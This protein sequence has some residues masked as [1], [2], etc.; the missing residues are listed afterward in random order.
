DGSLITIYGYNPNEDPYL[1]LRGAEP[2]T[3]SPEHMPEVDEEQVLELLAFVH[4]LSP[5]AGFEKMQREARS[6][7]VQYADVDVSDLR[8]PHMYDD[9]AQTGQTDG[10][11]GWL[12]RRSKPW[13]RLNAGIVAPFVGGERQISADGVAKITSVIIAESEQY[14]DWSVTS[15]KNLTLHNRHRVVGDMVRA[16]AQKMAA[17]EMGFEAIGTRRIDAITKVVEPDCGQG[18]KQGD[19]EYSWLPKTKDRK[20]I[21]SD[22]N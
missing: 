2:Y 5:I 21:G 3:T 17:G 10:R 7:P 8:V 14:L 12:L 19:G 15:G 20:R 18:V 9:A 6:E 16:T 22:D 13:V 1:W 11:R 4:S